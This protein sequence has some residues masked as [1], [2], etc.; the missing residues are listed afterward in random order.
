[1]QLSDFKYHVDY[2]WMKT[3]TDGKE[4]DIY[5]PAGR[6]E[7]FEAKIGKELKLL[8]EFLKDNTFVAYMLGPKMSGKGSYTAMLKEALGG[9]F[10]ELVSVG[11]LVREA[12]E[13]YLKDGKESDIYK[14]A[15][16]NYR[17]NIHVDEAIDAMLNRTQSA[18]MPTNMILTIIKRKID[19][20]GRKTV[21][22]DGFPRDLD[23]VS[24]SLYFRDLINYRN[25]PDCF[26]LINLPNE[27]IDARI[28]GRRICPT[29]K[30]SRNIVLAPSTLQEKKEDGSVVLMCDNTECKPQEMVKK[31]GDDKG[32]GLI[33][34]RIIID[35]QVMEAARKMHGIPKIELYN[36]V[37]KAKALELSDE[38]EYT[39]EHEYK[40]EKGEIVHT[41][42]PFSVVNDGVEY[43]SYM[44]A[45]VV[46]PFVRQLCD[47]FGLK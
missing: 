16:K 22:I 28:R 47:I 12:H 2:M 26:V 43:L 24:L 19:K 39:V 11:D 34:D 30:T 37:E 40:T 15:V 42:K 41:T 9:D 33:A 44:Q 18:L 17:G 45:V 7:Y 27:I 6:K 13:E 14:Y 29:C 8:R 5:G 10:I 32:I 4:Y 31:E 25:D 1:M 46:I 3:K 36:S 35:L 23:Q 38:Y 20:I 21:F